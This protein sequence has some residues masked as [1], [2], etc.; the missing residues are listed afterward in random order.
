MKYLVM[1][2]SH[3]KITTGSENGESTAYICDLHLKK[4]MGKQFL[5]ELSIKYQSNPKLTKNDA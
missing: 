3:Q 1:V 4:K 5:K 2:L